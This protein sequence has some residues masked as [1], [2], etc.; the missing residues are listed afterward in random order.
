MED[1]RVRNADKSRF[2]DLLGLFFF[3]GGCTDQMKLTRSV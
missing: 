1:V 2:P 3:S